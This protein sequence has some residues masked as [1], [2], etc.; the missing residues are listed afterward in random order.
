MNYEIF[1]KKQRTRAS[2]GIPYINIVILTLALAALFDSSCISLLLQRSYV[3]L[4]SIFMKW[5]PEPKY[6]G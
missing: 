6:Q 1:V 3:R 2:I 4:Y 5:I